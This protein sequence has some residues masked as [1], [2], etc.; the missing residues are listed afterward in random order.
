MDRQ[1]KFVIWG[2]G[3]IIALIASVIGAYQWSNH[4]P[5]RPHNVPPGAVYLRGLGLP[6]PHAPN[7]KW[8]S[9]HVQGN[10]QA[11]CFVF[12]AYGASRFQGAYVLL[13]G[14]SVSANALAHIDAD[15][16]ADLE[17]PAGSEQV[18][19]VFLADGSILIPEAA[20]P[21]SRA[22]VKEILDTSRSRH[23]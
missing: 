19:V 20:T 17:L 15:K 2:W 18:P 6:T 11:Y 22:W 7:G 23:P 16:S 12:E 1:T 4:V 8:L 14:T 13:K 3:I 9:C 5:L 21:S 10:R